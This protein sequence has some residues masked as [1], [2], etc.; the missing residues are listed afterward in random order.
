[1]PLFGKAK[2]GGAKI[3]PPLMP[4]YPHDPPCYEQPPHEHGEAIKAVAELVAR[5]VALGDTE[6]RRGEYR[7]QQSGVKVRQR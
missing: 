3:S 6:D 1:M 2:P 4:Q 7:K 5:G